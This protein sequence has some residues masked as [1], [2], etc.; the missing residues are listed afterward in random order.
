[1]QILTNTGGIASTNCFLIADEIAKEAILFDAPND[2]TAPLLDE[3][4]KR[5]WNL[6][7]L[8][9]THGHFDHMADH[10][11]VRA[12][13]PGVRV[14]AHEL[15]EPKLRKP[16]SF[17][18]LPFVL[19]PCKTDARV[20]DGQELKIGSILVRVMHTPGHAAGHVAYYLP[21]EG[22]LVGGDLIIA[23]SVGRTDLP[24][25]DP[26]LF[27]QTIRRVMELPG[28]TQLL[29]GHGERSTL[30]SERAENAYVRTM[31]GDK[32]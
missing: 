21:D 14:L 30:S 13:F 9:L 26:Q 27:M 7:G 19:T 10:T 31:L 8:W 3:A 23:G 16:G 29:P 24:D 15:E 12:R 1:M 32:A 28:A 4:K 2:T 22:V 25:S 5:G 18:P 11:V 17:F 6:V 20:I